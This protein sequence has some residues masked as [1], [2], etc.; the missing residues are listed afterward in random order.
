ML[1]VRVDRL[2]GPLKE[3]GETSMHQNRLSNF[4]LL[5]ME[6]DSLFE[7]NFD[8]TILIYLQH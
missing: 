2:G 4:L 1:A 8:D 7:I 5:S 6:R 3:L